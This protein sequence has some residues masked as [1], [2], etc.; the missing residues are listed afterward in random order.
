MLQ[1]IYIVKQSQRSYSTLKVK[2]VQKFNRPKQLYGQ[3]K[4]FHFYFPWKNFLTA[5]QNG[6]DEVCGIC[7]SKDNVQPLFHE[8]R[9]NVK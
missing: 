7:T 2:I 6:V 9:L 3:L 5:S 8:E 4:G 1:S